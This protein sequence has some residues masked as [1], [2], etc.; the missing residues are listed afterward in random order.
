MTE[1][2]KAKIKPPKKKKRWYSPGKII[3]YLFVLIIIVAAAMYFRVPQKIGLVKSPADKLFN[4]TPDREKAAAV[5]ADLQ[6]AGLN[7]QGVEVYI[8]PVKGTNDNVAMVVLDA[9][10]GF[11]FNS[12]GSPDPVKDFLAVLINAQK[13]GINR[14]GVAYYDE[15]GK[16]LVTATLPTEAALAYSQGKISN[17]QLMEKV[18]VGTDNI[19]GFI[20][21]VQGQLK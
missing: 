20:S 21:T 5:M 12:T 1:D 18:D 7:T 11:S 19:W 16:N 4:V 13:Q 9:S 2:T 17:R 10:K 14:A 6:A 8:L 15:N 3:L